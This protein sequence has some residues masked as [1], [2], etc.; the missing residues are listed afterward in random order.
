MHTANSEIADSDPPRARGPRGPAELTGGTVVWLYMVVEL[1]TFGAFFFVHAW[2]W[3]SS[4]EAHAASQAKLHP[5]SGLRGTFIL[6]LGSALA[7]HG[8]LAREAS[9]PYAASRWLVASA[10]SG[11]LFTVNKVAEYLDPA[12][13]DVTLSTSA[14][15]FSYFFLTALHLLHVIA[16]VG[17]LGWIAYRLRTRGDVGDG[18][19]IEAGAAYWHLVDVIW[20]L[21]FPI[22]YLMKP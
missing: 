13:A 14:F 5:A 10:A 21:L 12:L 22:L 11:V 19:T 6:L 15:W 1:V 17:L 2:G 8:V 16:G 18:L 9:R 7:Y 3:H 4:P 20:V